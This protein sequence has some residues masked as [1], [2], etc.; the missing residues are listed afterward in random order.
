MQW[1]YLSQSHERIAASE[2][3]LPLLAS[4]GTLRATTMLW[5]RGMSGWRPCGEVK[6]ELFTASVDRDSDHP[7]PAADAM[8]VR[9][10][11]AGMARTL[12]GYAVWLRVTGV[13]CLVA[14]LAVMVV[15]CQAGWHT[16]DRGLTFIAEHLPWHASIAEKGHTTIYTWVHFTMLL[17]AGFVLSALGVLLLRAAS[18]VVLARDT[19]SEPLLGRALQ[20]IGSWFALVVVWVLLNLVFWLSLTVWLGWDKA[21]EKESVLAVPAVS[22]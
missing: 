9:G 19:A 3:Q 6:P 7:H 10:A 1:Y 17:A 15:V 16:Y 5:R 20:S 13:I 8:A 18:R 12:A 22:V 4:R 11:V 21:W 2:E 14:S